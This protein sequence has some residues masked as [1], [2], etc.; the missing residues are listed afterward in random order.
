MKDLKRFEEAI[1][2]AKR[3]NVDSFSFDGM[4]VNI[5]VEVP[6]FPSYSE[7]SQPDDDLP[8]PKTSDY[9][10]NSPMMR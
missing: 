7:P 10:L 8:E 9:L 1:I 2:I 6:D 3:H 4:T 5:G